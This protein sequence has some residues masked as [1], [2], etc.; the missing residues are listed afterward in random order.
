[1]RLFLFI[2]LSALVAGCDSPEVTHTWSTLYG[3]SGRK[4]AVRVSE[5]SSDPDCEVVM[6]EYCQQIDGFGYTLT[7]REANMLAHMPIEDQH[8]LIYALHGEGGAGGEIIQ[9]AV[10]ASGYERYMEGDIDSKT[11][12]RSIYSSVAN[13]SLSFVPYLRNVLD[14]TG[15]KLIWTM[16]MRPSSD[17]VV[18]RGDRESMSLYADYLYLFLRNMLDAGVR[19]DMTSPQSDLDL[20]RQ[21]LVDER[22]VTR[23]VSRYLGPAMKDIDVRVCLGS[24]SSVSYDIDE[25][26]S[27]D[28][29]R[30]YISSV[31][32]CDTVNCRW[33]ADKC[34]G[35][36]IGK[37]IAVQDRTAEKG[38][39]KTWDRIRRMIRDGATGYVFSGLCDTTDIPSTLVVIDPDGRVDYN[40]DYFLFRQLSRNV[41]SGA[42]RIRT[43]GRFSDLLA[44]M[45]RDNSVVI[46]AVNRSKS[47][48]PLVV[49]V[50]D[51]SLR[52]TLP[53]ESVSTFVIKGDNGFIK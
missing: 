48:K 31:S 39:F 49:N 5:R 13:D 33:I 29:A 2:L 6:S 30:R 52:P 8:R 11:A 18:Y 1:M 7:S 46:V 36:G 53:A 37:I 14:F 16:P 47:P 41:T 45:N 27:D 19:V 34:Y 32:F 26:L 28:D 24:V 38:S 44:F 42:L 23:F 50:N 10:K 21:P 12:A 25:I 3:D 9:L 15:D 40:S 4:A 35:Y 22:S 20:M 51:Y 43:R 17:M